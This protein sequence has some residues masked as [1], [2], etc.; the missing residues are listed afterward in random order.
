MTGIVTP[1]VGRVRELSRLSAALTDAS[2]G[3]SSWIVVEGAP[4]I[5]KSALVEHFLRLHP[6]VTTS[7]A[8]GA[9]WESRYRYGVCEQLLRTSL[10]GG[11]QVDAARALLG[12]RDGTTVL[13]VDDAHWA[14][15]E[16]LQSL[17]SAIRRAGPQPLTV[18]LIMPDS[19]P[20]DMTDAAAQFF[21]DQRGYRVHVGPLSAADIAELARERIGIDMP[22]RT[23]RQLRDHTEGNPRL[24]EQ[25]LDETPPASWLEWQPELPV[26]RSH[27]ASVTRAL[28][29]VKPST[30]AIIQAAAVLGQDRSF[31]QVAA[32]ANVDDV[33]TALDEA[34]ASGLLMVRNPQGATIVHF[35]D[36]MTRA[37][38]LSDLPPTRQRDLHTRA[39]ALVQDE[40]RSLYH[41]VAATP[42]ADEALA[43]RLEE[44]ARSQ[45]S[46][47]AW[48]EVADALVT[49]S[50]MSP[51]KTVREDRL[52]RGVD[53]LVGAGDLP[54]ALALV[55]E[56]EAARE[57][58]Q[59]NAVLGY[60]AILRGRP[61]EAEHL[62][63][64]AWR[65][66]D[67]T[68]DPDTAAL[69]SQR[70]VL[71][72]LCRL[73][74][75]ELV[76]WVDR[77][78]ALVGPDEPA[79]IESEAIRGLGLAVMGRT[80]QARA[81]YTELSGRASLGAQ[82]QRFRMGKG[83]LEAT[84]DSPESARRELESAVPTVHRS[85]SVRISLWAQ[86]W[87]ARTHFLLGSWD[88]AL[89]TVSRAAVQI[90]DVG[91]EVVRP[92]T[93]WTGAAI[94]ALRGDW[95]RAEEHL[96]RA[97]AAAHNYEIML[98]PACLAQAQCAEVAA[99]YEG[100]LR[101]LE[102]LVAM[103]PRAGIDEP[104]PWPWPDSYANALVMTG[105]VDEADEFLVPY[106]RLAAERG[107]RSSAARMGS[108]RGRILGARS[109][110]DGAVDAFETALQLL[111]PLP[112]PFDRAK[113]TYSYGQTL[114][115]AGKR[116][117]ADALMRAA[118]DLYDALGAATYVQRCDRELKAGGLKATRTGSDRTDLTPQERAVADLVAAGL[119]NKEVA[120]EL[121]LSVKT[122]QYH[123]TRIYAKLGVRSRGELAAYLR[124]ENPKA[125]I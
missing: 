120:G 66:V 55:P 44:Y 107:H 49:A 18:I 56:I 24:V 9:R 34:T 8:A 67:P 14:D 40:G 28:S 2:A 111:S 39:A 105:R 114:R 87:L 15:I 95:P 38:V 23:A 58:A 100:V 91:L 53:A 36:P 96:R 70:M 101:V 116:R 3:L 32:L 75:A 7:W 125:Q 124:G 22:V 25:L 41:L 76:E 42:L 106:E 48:C 65:Q 103:R 110:I 113:V 79:A 81:S 64:T 62:L 73:R 35:P 98:A 57:S 13:V 1:L 115:R 112:L 69:I 84:L 82:A 10:S 12:L 104:G 27:A 119:S 74:G 33:M 30:R 121:F 109:D 85:G 43:E 52:V 31:H 11:D 63:R 72:S 59:R 78:V 60:L 47:G 89:A 86:A 50:R 94:H 90:D 45:A 118:R 20:A 46:M 61:E 71:H 4:G 6:A 80:E 16:S 77:A 102:P 19:A 123:L 5:G 17:A 68:D 122:I 26:P 97:G 117:E 37:A 54:Q 108:V 93:H 88:D 83:W 99:D 92:L 51:D 29:P 21:S